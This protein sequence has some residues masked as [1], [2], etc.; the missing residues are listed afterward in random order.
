MC[1]CHAPGTSNIANRVS[2]ARRIEQKAID[3]VRRA[4][5]ED[6]RG[7]YEEA[8]KLYKNALEYFMAD[9]KC[10]FQTRVGVTFAAG[11][12]GRG[13]ES[14]T[15]KPETGTPPGQRADSPLPLPLQTR[16]TNG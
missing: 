12:S 7:N 8:Y 10:W 4:T 16:R 14:W 6:T 1:V 15:S 2:D 5:E 9:V 11:T 13:L 3:I